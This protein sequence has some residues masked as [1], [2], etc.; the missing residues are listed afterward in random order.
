MRRL[1]AGVGGIAL[2]AS[3]SQFPEYAQQ[4]T[5]RLG[6][7][8]DELRVI[9]ED[10]DRAAQAG[11]MDRQGALQRYS[12]SN[13]TFLAG[14]GTSMAQ[15]FMRYEQLSA[16]LAR[17]EGAGPLERLQTLPAYL[18]SDIGQRTLENYRPAMPVTV[19]G[20]LYAGAGFILG[21]LLVSGIVRFCALPFRRRRHGH[22]YRA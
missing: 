5:Q 7:A 3:L 20:V 2:A 8:V 1:I 18:D 6:G 11:G 16:T 4:Y 21:Y 17:I 15:T 12:V 10:F 14:R 22:V 9:T 19:E 13:D